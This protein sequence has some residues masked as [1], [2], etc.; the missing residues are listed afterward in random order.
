MW[1]VVAYMRNEA[2]NLVDVIATRTD[3]LTGVIWR[4]SLTGQINTPQQR[5][6]LLQQIKDAYT[7]HL[8]EVVRHDDALAGLA[9]TA[10][11]ALND[12]EN[13]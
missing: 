7:N 6:G 11:N 10:E 8:A 2:T 3:D 12:W 1:E 9:D 5:Q 13:E 4:Y